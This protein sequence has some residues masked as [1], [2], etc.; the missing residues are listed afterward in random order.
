MLPARRVL[1]ALVLRPGH[2]R[3]LPR[4][5]WCVLS[6]SA[7]AGGGRQPADP[8]V[9]TAEAAR[10][11]AGA[12]AAARPLAS[13]APSG[14]VRGPSGHVHWHHPRRP[15]SKLL[16]AV[17]VLLG[18]LFHPY[19]MPADVRRLLPRSAA[20]AALAARATG[21]A[22]DATDAAAP[23]AQAAA[24]SSV[25]APAASTAVRASSATD[26]A[27]ATLAAGAAGAALAT[28]GATIATPTA[29]NAS[30]LT[31]SR[32]RGHRAS[33][34]LTTEQSVQQPF[35]GPSWHKPQSH[36]LSDP[37]CPSEH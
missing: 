22:S 4:H 26:A 2:P 6:R 21:P 17:P 34:V 18:L 37:H 24:V 23:A 30:T 28:P 36:G 13:A 5:V 14:H 1:L 7:A 10:R 8:S 3:R 9:V 20:L 27:T 11:S 31:P 33:R 29:T 35:R 19:G 12:A 15:T 25:T 32:L 16:P